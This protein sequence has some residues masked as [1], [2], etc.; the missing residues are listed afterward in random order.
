M[1]SFVD[2]FNRGLS[3]VPVNVG[4]I[5]SSLL[6]W[7]ADDMV[8]AGDAS[9]LE[10]LLD[11]LDPSLRIRIK[12][13]V[14]LRLPE[15]GARFRQRLQGDLIGLSK[16]FALSPGAATL[17]VADLAPATLYALRL[18]DARRPSAFGRIAAVLH[19][20]AAEIAGWRARNPLVRLTQLRS[21]MSWAPAR[22]RFVVL[23]ASIERALIQAAP[24][25]TGRLITLP[26][27]LPLRE[28]PNGGQKAWPDFASDVYPLKIAFLGAAQEKKGFGTYLSLARTVAAM[29]PGKVEFLAIGWLPPESENLDLACLTQPPGRLKI[30]RSEF[31][32][33]L[34]NVAYVCMPYDPDLYRFSA[35]GTLIDAVSSGKPVLAIRSPTLDDIQMEFG[36]IGDIAESAEELGEKISALMRAS[37][38]NR[39]RMQVENLV[40]VAASRSPKLLSQVWRAAWS[41]R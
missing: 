8:I 27:P 28:C 9:H 6:A 1:I 38:G 36:D 23:E 4:I 22:T 31:T 17:I 15:P 19:G 33:A 5:E 18:N 3:H 34:A 30:S 25:L 13:R 41:D 2:P 12:Y 35:S 24:E 16:V 10:G 11:L 29:W 14:P 21:A 40:R 37:D 20:N 32:A 7:P 39:Y 26:H